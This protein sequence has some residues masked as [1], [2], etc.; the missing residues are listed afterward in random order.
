MFPDALCRLPS[1]GSHLLVHVPKFQK[2]PHPGGDVSEFSD[3]RAQEQ[4]PPRPGTAGAKA[5]SRCPQL[6]RHPEAGAA[7]WAGQTHRHC[8]FGFLPL[9]LA[10]EAVAALSVLSKSHSRGRGR[11]GVE[12]RAESQPLSLNSWL[13]V[14]SAACGAAC[15]QRSPRWPSV[16]CPFQSPG[17]TWCCFHTDP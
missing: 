11:A 16:R 1:Q 5:L 13:R 2:R 8:R 7:L 17:K 15:R 4:C 12:P 10:R 3:P 6:P 9:V 14:Q